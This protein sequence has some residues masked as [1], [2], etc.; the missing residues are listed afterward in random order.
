M[1]WSGRG[2]T[3]DMVVVSQNG[4]LTPS[5]VLKVLGLNGPV[6][7]LSVDDVAPGSLVGGASVT[8]DVDSGSTTSGLTGGGAVG[9]DGGS[10]LAEGEMATG[11]VGSSGA[12]GI[13]TELVC[14]LT[15]VVVGFAVGPVCGGVDD[16]EEVAE[17]E[18]WR[19]EVVE[20]VVLVGAAAVTDGGVG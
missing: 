4:A 10:G 9:R 5:L 11:R 15:K 20:G 17:I 2:A 16:V 8:L 18:V 13:M 14:V 19:E 12:G 6:V 1:V 3:V 7:E